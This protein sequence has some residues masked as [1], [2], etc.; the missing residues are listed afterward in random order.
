MREKVIE[1]LARAGINNQQDMA[2]AN[3]KTVRMALGRDEDLIK[4]AVMWMC[5]GDPGRAYA[6]EPG[7]RPLLG[8]LYPGLKEIW[9]RLGDDDEAG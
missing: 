3:H 8:N 6:D 1:L 7:L 5:D 9:R 2:K 4:D